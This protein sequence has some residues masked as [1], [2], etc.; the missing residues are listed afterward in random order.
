M[1]RQIPG[2]SWALVRQSPGQARWSRCWFTCRDWRSRFRSSACWQG[3]TVAPCPHWRWAS[4]G[5]GLRPA[6]FASASGRTS[7][8]G[9][10]R[11]ASPCPP[12]RARPVASPRAR[13]GGLVLPLA[14]PPS[15]PGAVLG[16]TGGQGPWPCWPRS[17]TT[18]SG[19][20]PGA[21]R[22]TGRAGAGPARSVTSC[23][24]RAGGADSDR[25]EGLQ[26]RPGRDRA[27]PPPK[28]FPRAASGLVPG[29]C[30]FRGAPNGGARFR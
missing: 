8:L 17:T 24:P 4:L 20:A 21:S 3:R 12:V 16:G 5:A 30:V 9:R 1:G 19:T 11:L 7:R 2:R 14:G 26:T 29:R 15:W 23:A 13:P 18:W 6:P 22:L 27:T 25:D 28:L 10:L